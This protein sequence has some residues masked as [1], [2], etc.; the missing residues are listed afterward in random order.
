MSTWRVN[1][2]IMLEFA[3]FVSELVFR[4]RDKHG[5]WTAESEAA[6]YNQWDR[7]QG[8]Q[9]AFDFESTIRSRF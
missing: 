9:D 4:S 7:L 6:G 3:S 5:A 2:Q 1:Y 8:E